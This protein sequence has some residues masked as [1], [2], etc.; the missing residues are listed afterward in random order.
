MSKEAALLP[1]SERM[2]LLREAVNVVVKKDFEP[3][4]VVI[5]VKAI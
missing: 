5:L 3:A 1:C 4:A 2:A